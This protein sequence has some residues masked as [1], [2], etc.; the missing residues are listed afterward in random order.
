MLTRAWGSGPRIPYHTGYEMAPR[1][2]SSTIVTQSISLAGSARHT[3]SPALRSSP[4]K[5]YSYSARGEQHA[6]TTRN[7][8][9]RTSCDLIPQKR[10]TEECYSILGAMTHEFPT[11]ILGK[12]Y[13]DAM[14][15]YICSS[16]TFKPVGGVQVWRSIKPDRWYFKKGRTSRIT[17]GFCNGVES[18]INMRETRYLRDRDASIRQIINPDPKSETPDYAGEWIIIN[19]HSDHRVFTRQGTFCNKGECGSLILDHY[20]RAAGLMIGDLHGFQGPEIPVPVSTDAAAPASH[21]SMASEHHPP[22][23]RK[24]PCGWNNLGYQGRAC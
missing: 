3:N 19:A 15:I 22:Y 13:S 1:S 9:R 17:A 14:A 5:H 18:Y 2:F 21:V 20:G 23:G 6:K 16:F 24:L 8:L 12:A 10:F 7:L 11:Q 4:R